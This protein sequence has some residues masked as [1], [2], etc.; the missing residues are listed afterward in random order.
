MS[1]MAFSFTST[2]LAP[3]AL[4]SAPRPRRPTRQ[5][6]ATH[7]IKDI[8]E[9]ER[10]PGAEMIEDTISFLKEDLQHLFDDQGIDTSRYDSVVDFQDPVT[11]YSSIQGYVFNLRLLRNVFSPVFTLHDI[12]Q[13]GEYELTTRWTME[14]NFTPA[15][16]TPLKSVWNP[17]LTFTGLSL[18]GLNPENGKIN[19][20]VDLWDA[21]DN[22]QFPSLEG[23]IHVFRQLLDV[24]RTPDLETPGY[25]VLKK[26]KEYEI[27]RYLPFL[28][29]ETKMET[30]KGMTEFNPASRSG[31]SAFNQLA[32]YIFGNNEQKR[33]MEMTTPV[34][35]DTTGNMQFVLG[36]NFKEAADLPAPDSK[37]VDAKQ[38]QGGLFA[39]S[40]FSG[41]AAE[42]QVTREHARLEKAMRKDK[43]VPENEWILARY[44]DP[45]TNPLVR[46][47]EIL[48][49]I[50]RGFSLW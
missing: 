39:C 28:V 27:R 4:F 14:M 35:T 32:G 36:S 8:V 29:A 2:R 26:T 17:K 50:E 40:M 45:F 44:N 33:K 41:A 49:P 6:P 12:R 3:R 5:L 25:T 23:F 22:Q 31:G 37:E 16:N 42:E 15:S 11:S 1:N 47:N 43:L 18:Y 20:H 7:T 9:A 48:I 13:T 24:S 21:I 46:R 38:V 34:F 19:K 10:S 30:P